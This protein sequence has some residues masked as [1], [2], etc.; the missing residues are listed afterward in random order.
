MGTRRV[1]RK[2]FIVP[3]CTRACPA[4]VDVPRYIRLARDGNYDEAVAVLREKLPLPTVCADAC[5][6]PCEEMC[7]YRQFGDPI[8][9]RAIK[10]AAVDKGKEGWKKRKKVASRTGKKVAVVGAGPAGLTAA[11]YLVTKGHDVTVYDAFPKPGGMLRYGIPNYRL[12]EERLERDISSIM[13]WGVRFQGNTQVGKD[14]SM[15]KLKKDHDA[16]FLAG[17]ANGSIRIPLEGSKKKGVLWGWDFLRDVKLGKVSKIKGDAI[18]VGGGNVAIDVALT[19]K[20]LGAGN[21]HLF[22]LEKR[23]EMPA[24]EWEIARAEE[25][26]VFIHN[27][28]APRKVLGDRSATGLGLI[29]C[30]SVFDKAGNFNPTYDQAIS[31]KVDG[32]T[33]LLA[34]GQAAELEYL[35]GEKGIILEKGRIKVDE[36]GLATGAKGVFAGGDVVTGPQSIISAIAH[37][38]KAASAMDLYLGGNGRI[39]EV[40]AKPEKEVLLSEFL[41]QVRPR[42]NMALLK[43]W[44]R[45]AGFDQV[46]RGLTDRQIAAEADRC[47]QCDARKFEVVLNTE[48]CKECGYCAE[49]C[50]VGT[51]GPA[52]FFNAKGYRPQQVKTSDWCVGCSRCYFA[53]PD[54]AIDIK[55]SAA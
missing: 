53:C 36:E 20:R 30:T 47:L 32:T 38:R 28:W 1:Q 15:A 13:G 40:L 11:Y 18:V 4:G 46:E 43:T 7:A 48:Y 3:L 37:G 29:Q 27:S 19:S 22:C 14:I 10:R 44:E 45:T 21:V 31:H 54:F 5:F 34:V 8:A 12:P 51:F 50:G 35:E 42:N 6:A 24:H 25:E 39:D 41:V 17:G 16:V 52:D 49:V 23:E 2:D 9:I 33:I 26:G 55:E